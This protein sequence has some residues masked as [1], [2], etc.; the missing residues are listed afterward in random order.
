MKDRLKEFE[1]TSKAINAGNKSKLFLRLGFDLSL[2]LIR[3]ETAF[4]FDPRGFA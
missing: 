2:K 4:Q 1:V 3:S